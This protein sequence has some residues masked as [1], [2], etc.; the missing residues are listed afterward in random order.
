MPE[1]AKLTPTLRRALLAL[2][3][4]ALTAGA[5]YRAVPHVR[6]ADVR[7]DRPDMARY[8]PTRFGAWRVD[9]TDQHG[10]VNPQTTE[11]LDKLYSQLLNRVYVDDQGHRVM[12][13]VAYGNDQRDQ[14]AFHF[15]EVCYPAQ[16]FIVNKA[17][18]AQLHVG[19]LQL[20]ARQLETAQGKQRPEPVTYWAV[21]GERVVRGKLDRNFVQLRYG[22]RGQI[23]DGALIRVSTIGPDA[24]EEFAVQAAFIN[25][26]LAA[27]TPTARAFFLGQPQG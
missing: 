17:I 23:P 12:L 25:Q 26:M 4:M 20:A 24:A 27:M 9:E 16:G 5:A 7:A 1:H 13:A 11:L 6:L 19:Q 14:L 10:V 22:L 3:L 18:D 21:V 8:V 2:A 15:P